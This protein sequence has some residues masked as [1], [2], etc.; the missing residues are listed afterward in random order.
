MTD[1]CEPDAEDCVRF[2]GAHIVLGR[3]R[4]RLRRYCCGRRHDSDYGH[5]A[6]EHRVCRAVVCID[7]PYISAEHLRI[8]VSDLAASAARGSLRSVPRNAR[9]SLMEARRCT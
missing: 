3:D 2:K 7:D 9:Q 4:K 8:D 6:A 5:N 1:V